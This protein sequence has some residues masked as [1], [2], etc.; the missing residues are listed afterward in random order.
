MRTGASA[1]TPYSYYINKVN[2]AALITCQIKNPSSFLTSR[3]DLDLFQ[4]SPADSGFYSCVAGN[5]LGES[6]STA[7][8][9][10]SA[11]PGLRVTGALVVASL[12]ALGLAS[13]HILSDLGLTR[14]LVRTSGL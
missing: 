1:G 13:P 11:A 7:H 6:V 9:A 5:I 2:S 14:R 12:L 4:V 10:I 3:N 8:L